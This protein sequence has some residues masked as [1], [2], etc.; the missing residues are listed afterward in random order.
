MQYD[1]NERCTD[2]VMVMK[3]FCKLCGAW[4]GTCQDLVRTVLS[5]MCEERHGG[6]QSLPCPAVTPLI[7]PSGSGFSIHVAAG[8]VHDTASEFSLL[9]HRT[10]VSHQ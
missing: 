10:A 6:S 7:V 5:G 1:I 2:I 9:Q 3:W 8:P 4:T